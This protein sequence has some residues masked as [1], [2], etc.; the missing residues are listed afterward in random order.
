MFINITVRYLLLIT[1]VTLGRDMMLACYNTLSIVF[2]LHG[3]PLAVDLDKGLSMCSG[4]RHAAEPCFSIIWPKNMAMCR[5][6]CT[7]DVPNISSGLFPTSQPHNTPLIS[8]PHTVSILCL[9]IYFSHSYKFFPFFCL[10]LTVSP[11][12]SF[13]L[14]A[15]CPISPCRP[16]PHSSVSGRKVEWVCGSP[17]E[18][19]GLCLEESWRIPPYFS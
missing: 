4:G 10:S 9:F 17:R 2:L 18:Q 7:T 15:L 14:T 3:K 11:P 6:G 16:R 13:P 8:T 19:Q 5:V 1:C 12:N